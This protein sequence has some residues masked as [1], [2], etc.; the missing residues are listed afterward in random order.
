M[1]GTVR[2]RSLVLTL[3]FALLTFGTQA[4]GAV[5]SAGNVAPVA[6]GDPLTMDAETIMQ[7]DD[8]VAWD[9][10]GGSVAIDGDVAVVG[11]LS[12]N[13]GAGAAYVYERID[14]TWVET[15]KLVSTD[16]GANERFGASVAVEGDTIVVGEHRDLDVNVAKGAVHVFTR[17]GGAWSHAAKLVASPRVDNGE[18]GCDV[19]ISG[20]T[21]AIG[22]YGYSGY[23]GGAYVFQGGGSSWTQQAVIGPASSGSHAFGESLDIDGDTLLVGCPN[24]DALGSDSGAAYIYTRSGA[25]WSYGAQLVASDGAANDYFGG[26][27]AIDGGVALVGAR[28][29]DDLGNWSGAAYLFKGSGSSWT[30]FDKILPSDGAAQDEFGSDVAFDGQSAVIGAQKTSQLGAATGRAYVYTYN[31]TGLTEVSALSASDAAADAYYGSA[32]AISGST[33]VVGA[34]SASPT[35][36]NS[37]EAYIYDSYYTVAEDAVLYVDAPGVLWNDWDSDMEWFGVADWAEA[38]H[39]H[40]SMFSGGAFSYTPEPDFNGYDSFTYRLWDDHG[41]FSA[42]ATVKIRVAPVHDYIPI[43]GADRFETSA[44]AARA[45]FAASGAPTAVIATGRNFP[46]ALGGSALAGALDAPLLLVD[47]ASVPASVADVLDELDTDHAIILGGT[48][49]VTDAVRTQLIAAMGSGSTVERIDGR[50][51]Y[52]TAREVAA[53]AIDEIGP[54]FDGVAFVATGEN[55]PDALAAGP[56]AAAFG[57]PIYL[58][59]NGAGDAATIAAMDADGVSSVN[60]LGGT[61]VVTGATYAALTSEFGTGRVDRLSGDNRYETAAEVA[62]YGCAKDKLTWNGVGIA[63]GEAFPDALSAGAT[64]G[65]FRTVLMLSRPAAL[66]TETESVLSANRTAIDDVR[67]FGGTSALSPAVRARVK[68]VIEAP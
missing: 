5:T 31:G 63:T 30:Q 19:A 67:Y 24:D 53:R 46:D 38:G 18:F 25:S 4:A 57:M 2:S 39:G 61:S 26:A 60:V 17:S 33:C 21:I 68:Q 47:T 36:E 10:L 41:A 32:V 35:A 66:S 48:A 64:L 15:A 45:G 6:Q 59:S 56:I 28:A 11:A 29:D 42:P 34:Y 22:S 50:D 12:G 40:V 62:S 49:A 51:R 54:L 58:V 55:F 44:E 13:N 37:G 52:E 65:R 1:N 20:D 9:Q 3:I 43:Q 8:L 27:V 16:P 23:A 14:G 7:P